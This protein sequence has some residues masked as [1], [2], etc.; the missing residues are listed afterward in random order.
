MRGPAC[1]GRPAGASAVT[2]TV[3]PLNTATDRNAGAVPAQDAKAPTSGPAMDPAERRP[4]TMPD[5][6]PRLFG[7]ALWVTQAIEAVQTVPL[8]MPCR[9]RAAT[10]V[11]AF[12]ANANT[13]V[14][15]VITTLD[16]SAIRRPPMR[17]ASGMHAS[18]TSGLAAG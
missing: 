3:T 9:K 13:T 12:G 7:G 14:A 18:A 10:S 1:I 17:G 16:P 4:I 11:S 5:S 6:R 8:A 2:T 15:R